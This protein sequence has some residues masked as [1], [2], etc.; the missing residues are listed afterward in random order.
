ML[1]KEDTKSL[2]TLIFEDL[3]CRWGPITEIVTNNRPAFRAA[4]DDLA[5][6]YGI[7]PIRI[8]PYNSQANSIVERR[9]YD[10][11]EAIIK[12]CNGDKSQWY[13]V[14]HVVLWAECVTVHQVTGFTPYFMVHGVEPIFPF[15]LTEGT[16]LVALP[17]QETF[18][19][20]DL[21]AWWA[22]QLQKRQQDLNDIKEKVLKACYQSIHNFE[23]CYHRLIVDYNFKPGAYVL[24]RNSKV[25]YELSHKT[26]PHYLGPMIVVCHTKGG[27]YILAE[28]DGVVSKLCYVVFCLLPYL[29]RNKNKISVTSIMGLDEEALNS[30]A[31]ENVEEPDNEV[32]NFDLIV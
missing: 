4:V 6:R 13:K 30:L 9:H 20:M 5:E 8:S 19:T 28:L 21:V 3:L 22:H 16:F 32:L 18:S 7:H 10:V 26:K 31:S 17:D 14:T 11:W 23:Q 29:P 1:C 12:S 25:E 27:A 24:V 2:G 15:D